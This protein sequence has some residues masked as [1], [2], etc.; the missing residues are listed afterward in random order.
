MLNLTY[1]SG[2]RGE[3]GWN[4]SWLGYLS[5]LGEVSHKFPHFCMCLCQDISSNW[6]LM[7]SFCNPLELVSGYSVI[8]L[9]FNCVCVLSY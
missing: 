9:S 1:L 2:S 4:K 5:V 6:V 8:T 7:A 3:M